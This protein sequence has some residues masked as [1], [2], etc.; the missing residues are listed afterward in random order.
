MA[1]FVVQ[2]S[3]D[4]Y[5]VTSLF[6]SLREGKGLFFLIS[7]GSQH[8]RTAGVQPD[9]AITSFR[10]SDHFCPI[11]HLLPWNLEPYRGSPE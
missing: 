3:Q 7:T 4:F 11:L 5:L 2:A 9:T 6:S 8:G 10:S 1:T